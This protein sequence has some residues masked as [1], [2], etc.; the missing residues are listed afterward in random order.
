MTV[1]DKDATIQAILN[2]TPYETLDELRQVCKHPPDPNDPQTT[3]L[4]GVLSAINTIQQGV[5]NLT[6]TDELI[7]M[8]Q[9]CDWL[10]SFAAP[11]SD[12]KTVYGT[13][14]KA[15]ETAIRINILGKGPKPTKQK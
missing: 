5:T 3:S 6:I 8:S 7:P 2:T 11:P 14:H 9:M 12:D 10:S 15:W 1:L 4:C 13:I